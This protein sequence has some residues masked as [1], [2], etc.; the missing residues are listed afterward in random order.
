MSA[1]LPIT[2]TEIAIGSEIVRVELKLYNGRPLFSAWRVSPSF[3][4]YR[5]ARCD[6]HGYARE[7]GAPVPDPAVL[8]KAKAEARR[9][10]ATT[11]ETKRRKARWL[12]GQRRPIVGTAA[13][14]YLREVR[15]YA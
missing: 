10:A 7:D 1:A 12:W 8:A 11:A 13:E 4:T 2:V 3:V 15:C 5:C 6:I 9:L 14:R